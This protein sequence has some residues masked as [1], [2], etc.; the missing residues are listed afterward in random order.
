MVKKAVV[1]GAILFY[2]TFNKA[3]NIIHITHPNYSLILTS[4]HCDIYN[5]YETLSLLFAN[6]RERG[7]TV[8]DNLEVEN[9]SIVLDPT[10]SGEMITLLSEFK[11]SINKYLQELIY[12]PVRSLAEII[13]FN[14]NHPV[15]V[16]TIYTFNLI[17]INFKYFHLCFQILSTLLLYI[18]YKI[19]IWHRKSM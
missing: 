10:Q 1:Y 11:L 9:L 5:N 17:Y 3:K 15:L 14:I 16:S 8:V 13:E 12:S 19:L 18:M 6:S 7:A 2:L 4:I